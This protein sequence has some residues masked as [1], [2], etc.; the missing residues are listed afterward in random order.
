MCWGGGGSCRA[1]NGVLYED[2]YGVE[3]TH[4]DLDQQNSLAK[5]KKTDKEEER[6]VARSQFSKPSAARNK[7]GSFVPLARL[8]LIISS[9][10]PCCRTS[11]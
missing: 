9:C 6:G 4:G 5:K 2:G 8:V 1:T 7:R 3:I 11:S 10:L